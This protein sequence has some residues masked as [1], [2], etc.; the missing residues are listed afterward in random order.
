MQRYGRYRITEGDRKQSYDPE[1]I[2]DIQ[3]SYE[4]GPGVLKLGA[5]NVFDVEPDKDKISRTRAGTIVDAEGN[6]I[7]ASD[8]V[9]TYSRRAAPFGFNGGFYYAT[10]E[11]QF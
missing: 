11:Y 8:G 3:L 7:V 6:T 5:D 1:F 9:F 4:L 10:F 2:T